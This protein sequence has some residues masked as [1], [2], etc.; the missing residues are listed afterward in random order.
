MH[1][2]RRDL[3]LAGAGTALAATPLL[4]AAPA[5]AAPAGTTTPGGTAAADG[6]GPATGPGATA[7]RLP[8]D[9]LDAGIGAITDAGM[10][11][12]FAEARDGRDRWRGASGIADLDTGRPMRPGLQHR[13]GSITKTF[14]AAT[15]LRLAG[16]G[17][18]A[19]D[20]P[21]GRYLPEYAVPGVTVEMLLNHTSGIGDYDTVLFTSGY[22][23]ERLRFTTF[24]PDQLVRIGLGEPRTGAPGAGFAYS[25]TNYILAGLVVE[26]VTG[27]GAADEVHR[28]VIRPLGLH[29]T[30]FPGR[31]TRIAG[32]HSEAYLPWYDGQLRD[33]SVAN[34]SW[35]WTAGALVSTAADLNRFFRA[36]LGGRLLRPA[37]LARMRTTVPLDPTQP[38]AGGYGLGLLWLALP[39]GRLWGH[40]GVV[41]GHATISLHAPDGSRQVTLGT[42]VTHYQVPGQPDPIGAATGAFLVTALSG[43]VTAR[44]AGATRTPTPATPLPAPL[45]ATPAPGSPAL[46]RPLPR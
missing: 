12:V 32:P 42:N 22:D 43:A 40:D 10:V 41:F 8:A 28:R 1:L 44:S 34:M 33:F 11:G 21:L 24:T 19:L 7:G 18:V 38:E 25:N 30:Y 3:L 15:L 26:R 45:P 35:A 6:S 36:L 14:V 37:E 46:T 16:E 27:R 31:R 17:R 9:A 4:A 29:Q 5:T 13:V 39:G 23:V 2:S 20:A